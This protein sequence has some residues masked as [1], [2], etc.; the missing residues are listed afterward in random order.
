MRKESA[1]EKCVCRV[2]GLLV[3]VA[4]ASPASAQAV[5]WQMLVIPSPTSTP[6]PRV[7][8]LPPGTGDG[9][10]CPRGAVGHFDAAVNAAINR[11]IRVNPEYFDLDDEIAPHCPRIRR[12]HVDRYLQAVPRYLRLAGYCAIWDGAEVAVKNRNAF[13]DQYHIWWS[14][15]YVRRPPSAYRATCRPAWF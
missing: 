1:M 14:S 10:D 8:T 15:F 3:L 11:V 7:C 2:V 6:R 5:R 9:V 13:S 4:I 12:E